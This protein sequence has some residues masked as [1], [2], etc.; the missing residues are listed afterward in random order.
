MV[1]AGSINKEIVMAI[2]VPWEAFGAR[3]GIGDVWLGNLF[4]CVGTGSTRGY[5]AWQPTETETPNFH[6][7]EKFGEFLFEK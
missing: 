3:P 1:L 2:K 4:R 5:L 6:V 7:P